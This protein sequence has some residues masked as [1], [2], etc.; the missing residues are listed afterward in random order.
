MLKLMLSY[1]GHV[2]SRQDTLEKTI[3][4][5]NVEGSR[6]RGR[7][8]IRWTDTL[9]K[10]QAL[11]LQE[12]SRAVEDRTF[13]SLLIHKVAINQGQLDGTSQPQFSF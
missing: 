4:L 8:N 11:I 12:L 9:R 1:F 10:S 6:E 13:W 2:M 3:M 7:P 5:G